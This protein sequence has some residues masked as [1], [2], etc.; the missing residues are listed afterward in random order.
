MLRG[1][2]PDNGSL[3]GAATNLPLPPP[4]GATRSEDTRLPIG[5]L[6]VRDGVLTAQQLESVLTEKERSGRRLGEIVVANGWVSAAQIAKL[7]AEQ[8][9]LEYLD[10]TR[11]EIEPP[12]AGLLPEQFARRYEALP[13]RFLTEDTVLVAV[14]DPTNVVTSDDLRLALGLNVRVAVAG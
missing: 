6:L 14:T 4:A 10:L 2:Y 11:V 8:H 5:T 12:A 3:E 13:I 1:R 9:G 7:L